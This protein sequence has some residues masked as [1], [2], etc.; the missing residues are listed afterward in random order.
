MRTT[1]ASSEMRL[2]LVPQTLG[3]VNVK[4]VVEAGNVSAH[5]LAQTSEVRDALTAAQPLLTKALADAGLK[6]TS[7]RVDVSGDG[8]AGFSQQQN[9]QSQNGSRPRRT[10]ADFG[11][12]DGEDDTGLDAIPS[13]GPSIAARPSA[14]DYNYLA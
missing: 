5:V 2:S 11:A 8:F 3:D 7:L 9:D 12:D 6:L 10:S 14:G 4:L 13:F 1:G